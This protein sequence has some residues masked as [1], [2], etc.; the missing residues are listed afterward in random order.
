MSY[1]ESRNKKL[2]D[3]VEDYIETGE[4]NIELLYDK[5]SLEFDNTIQE[6]NMLENNEEYL[7]EVSQFKSLINDLKGTELLILSKVREGDPV[8]ALQYFEDNYDERKR[9]ASHLAVAIVEKKLGEVSKKIAEGN[10]IAD[11]TRNILLSMLIFAGSFMIFVAFLLASYISRPI[12]KLVDAVIKIGEGDLKTRV[13]INSNDEIGILAKEFNRMTAKLE[14]SYENL[15]SK[16]KSRTE[17]LEEKVDELENIREG[18]ERA[19]E[20]LDEV[21]TLS[22]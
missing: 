4:Q 10:N 7:S 1:L 13:D 6:L 19:V 3:Y 5:T 22:K 21:R 18:M 12:K 15:E 20:T 8:L 9:A 16:V 14:K 11:N 17:E 2:G